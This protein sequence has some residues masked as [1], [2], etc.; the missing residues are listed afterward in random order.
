MWCQVVYESIY[1]HSFYLPLGLQVC[2]ESP[3]LTGLQKHWDN[4]GT[5]KFNLWAAC[6]ILIVPDCLSFV[7]AAVVWGIVNG[8]SGFDLSSGIVALRYL[9]LL[10]AY[11]LVT[12]SSDCVDVLAVAGHQFSLFCA[13]FDAI[14]SWCFLQRLLVLLIPLWFLLGVNVIG[15]K[16]IFT[17]LPPVLT[18]PSWSSTVSVIFPSRKMLMR[19]MRADSPASSRHLRPEALL[20]TALEVLVAFL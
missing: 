7:R 15:K 9:S 8:I 10:T 14:L 2:C 17:G 13:D 19:V 18:A 4:Q 16:H 12:N 11:V 5:H 6:N 3:G 20:Y 1:F